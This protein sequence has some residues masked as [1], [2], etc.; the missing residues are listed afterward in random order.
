MGNMDAGQNKTKANATNNTSQKSGGSKQVN[1]TVNVT[2]PTIAVEN[3]QPKT[4]VD[5]ASKKVE[6][7]LTQKWLALKKEND[8]M[9]Q[10]LK[11][12]KKDSLR[13]DSIK[14]G[15]KKLPLE[16]KEKTSSTGASK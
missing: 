7:A 14:R 3:K 6:S 5:T 10:E 8:R 12:R 2:K 13:L 15:L 1:N 11:A 9:E 16:Q 4:A